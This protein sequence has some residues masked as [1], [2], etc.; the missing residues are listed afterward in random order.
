MTSLGEK[1]D[2]GRARHARCTSNIILTAALHT[3]LPRWVKRV[4]PAVS[5][6][7]FTLDSGRIAARRRTDTSGQ[8]RKLPAPLDHLARVTIGESEA[9]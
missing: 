8:N 2:G 3:R 4:G 6:V 9:D 7:G 5:H 1:K